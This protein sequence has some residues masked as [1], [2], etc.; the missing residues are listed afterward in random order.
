[1][2]ESERPPTPK[3]TAEEH[4]YFQTLG[5]QNAQLPPVSPPPPRTG[6]QV[7]E[8][9]N[10]IARLAVPSDVDSQGDLDGHLKL[11]AALEAKAKPPIARAKACTR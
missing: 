1:M 9:M 5:R 4:R 3:A 2:Q 6:V 10:R 7:V 11:I 8:E